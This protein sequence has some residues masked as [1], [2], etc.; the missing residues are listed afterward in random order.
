MCLCIL[1]VVT[2]CKD[3][4]STNNAL[5]EEWTGPY[6][7][8]PAFDKMQVA[9]VQSAVEQGMIEN[10]KEID[11]IAASEPPT[12]ENTIEAMERSGSTLDRVFSY[13]G[14]LSSNM[15]SPEFREVNPFW[16]LNYLNFHRKSVKMKNCLNV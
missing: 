11:A 7:G 10:L 5:L 6:G 12:F 3:I 16:P 1:S 15:S 13:Y 4:E 9:D 14:I 2:S 8:V